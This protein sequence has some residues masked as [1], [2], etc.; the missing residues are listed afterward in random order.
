MYVESVIGNKIEVKIQNLV[1]RTNK[2][3]H[4][5]SIQITNIP[6]LHTW[7]FE[8]TTAS[9]LQGITVNSCNTQIQDSVPEYTV[10]LTME[11]I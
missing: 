2:P 4:V 8:Q 7:L 9:M 11:G 10:Y 6:V 5:A 1:S 3:N